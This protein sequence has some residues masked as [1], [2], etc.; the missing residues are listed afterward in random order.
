M[1]LTIS[2][3]NSNMCIYVKCGVGPLPSLCRSLL[4]FSFSMCLFIVFVLSIPSSPTYRGASAASLS[5]SLAAAP[6]A[7]AAPPPHRGDGQRRGGGEEGAT[8]TATMMMMM[9][10]PQKRPMM[11]PLASHPLCRQF[12]CL[13]RHHHH[14]HHR[15]HQPH[16]QR[17]LHNHLSSLVQ[18]TT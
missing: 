10:Q 6:G 2:G 9:I 11:L 7:T 8:K 15:H 16:Q 3:R 17:S 12:H 13:R 1:V 5:W 4:I 18:T 14:R